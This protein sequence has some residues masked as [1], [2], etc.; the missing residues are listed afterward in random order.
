MERIVVKGIYEHV[1]VLIDASGQVNSTAMS[2]MRDTGS[3]V[4][5]LKS[6]LMK[7][8]QMTGSYDWCV[9]INGMVRWYSTAVV[10]LD[11]HSYV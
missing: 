9:L 10:D 11:T 7:P 1:T 4:C 3:T 8:E 6:T 2:V 5:M